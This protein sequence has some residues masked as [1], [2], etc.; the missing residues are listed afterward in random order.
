MTF[1]KFPVHKV[2]TTLGVCEV[3][4]GRSELDL[5]ERGGFTAH[6]TEAEGEVLSLEAYRL[7]VKAYLAELYRARH[8]RKPGS[9][10][11]NL[12]SHQLMDDL[13]GWTKLNWQPPK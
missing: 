8:G 13:T 3:K 9:V 10:T 5:D 6:W 4:L 1:H 11:L 12:A 2:R 7:I